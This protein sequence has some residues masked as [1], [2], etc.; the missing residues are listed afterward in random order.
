MLLYLATRAC[1]SN[2][3]HDNGKLH[4]LILHDTKHTS[5]YILAQETF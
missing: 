5:A 2:D 3:L 4:R 1:A